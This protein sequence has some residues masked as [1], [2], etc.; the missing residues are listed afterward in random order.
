DHLDSTPF[1]YAALFRSCLSQSSAR[2]PGEISLSAALKSD[3]TYA[4]TQK[5]SINDFE[6]VGVLRSKVL[7][8]G[9][10]AVDYTVIANLVD[11]LERSE[12]HTSE[13]QS[14]EN[15]V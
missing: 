3:R 4:L 2:D 10:L 7:D 12:E 14:R 9:V 11:V 5:R 8:R 13:L 15:L 6:A 1:P